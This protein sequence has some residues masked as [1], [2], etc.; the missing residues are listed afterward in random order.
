MWVSFPRYSSMLNTSTPCPGIYFIVSRWHC[1]IFH[2][3]LWSKCWHPSWNFEYHSGTSFVTNH[4]VWSPR[5]YLQRVFV[6]TSATMNWLLIQINFCHNFSPP[7]LT[8]WNLQWIW[9]AFFVSLKETL[10]STAVLLSMR[11]S[12]GKSSFDP[13]LISSMWLR[14]MC[15]FPVAIHSRQAQLY[16]AY[17]LLLATGMGMLL[18]WSNTPPW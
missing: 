14:V 17:A 12:T 5:G 4:W 11:I 16:S 15:I 6:V 9:Q 8:K 7:C 18:E 10:I 1:T 13:S 3:T 2:F